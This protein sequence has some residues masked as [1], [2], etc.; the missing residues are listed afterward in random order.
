MING[1]CCEKLFLISFKTTTHD[2]ISRLNYDNSGHANLFIVK[3]GRRGED[4]TSSTKLIIYGMNQSSLR[5]QA[6]SLTC[7]NTHIG[8]WVKLHDK[9]DGLSQR[10]VSQP[11]SRYASDISWAL[12][13]TSPSWSWYAAPKTN[14]RKKKRKKKQGSIK[15][16]QAKQTT[17]GEKNK[18]N[19]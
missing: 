15:R 10:D 8:Q 3:A 9:I 6:R 16:K 7:Y 13:G 4:G 2:M 1:N 11:L 18:A 12:D 19:G 14:K 5:L 17:S